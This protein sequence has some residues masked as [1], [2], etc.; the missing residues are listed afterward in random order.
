MILSLSLFERVDIFKL[1]Y[2][3]LSL[4]I[5][6]VPRTRTINTVVVLVYLRARPGV[7]ATLFRKWTTKLGL[8]R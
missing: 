2:S 6:L 3:V 1:S 7:V 5:Y 8:A 4:N